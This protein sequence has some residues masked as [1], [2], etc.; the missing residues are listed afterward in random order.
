MVRSLI[1][2]MKSGVSKYFEISMQVLYLL[3]YCRYAIVQQFSTKTLKETGEIC[4]DPS[5]S[6]LRGL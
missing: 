3:Y 1:Y 2:K 6:C 4:T 5:E